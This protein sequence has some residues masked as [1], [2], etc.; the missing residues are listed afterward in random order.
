[1]EICIG[2]TMVSKNCRTTCT[3]YSLKHRF[4]SLCD[5]ASLTVSISMSSINKRNIRRFCNYR[6]QVFGVLRVP[7]CI[8]SFLLWLLNPSRLSLDNP[9]AIIHLATVRDIRLQFVQ[10][11]QVQK[12][13]I[14][15]YYFVLAY[16]YLFIIF[17]AYCMCT[18]CKYISS[19]AAQFSNLISTLYVGQRVHY[20]VYVALILSYF[21][22]YFAYT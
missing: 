15:L 12:R 5:I 6:V 9:M 11:V 22:W 20:S 1:M 13:N 19:V 8:S 2:A 14:T 16:Y 7:R 17:I 4:Q 3:C 21:S 10:M 18:N